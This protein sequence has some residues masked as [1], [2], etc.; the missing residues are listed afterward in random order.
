[1]KTKIRPGHAAM[2]QMNDR[3]AELGDGQSAD[4]AG[5]GHAEPADPGYAVPM[6]YSYAV[7][8]GPGH[9]DPARYARAVPAGPGRPPHQKNPPLFSCMGRQSTGMWAS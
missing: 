9:A 1:M 4:P 5:P 7:R 3:L 6:S 2:L 8:T